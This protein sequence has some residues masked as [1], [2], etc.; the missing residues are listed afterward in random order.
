[1]TSYGGAD[2]QIHPTELHSRIEVYSVVIASQP[3]DAIRPASL[4][5]HEIEAA[6]RK[7]VAAKTSDHRL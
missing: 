1:V 4:G 5:R 3:V 6:T 7:A 2:G